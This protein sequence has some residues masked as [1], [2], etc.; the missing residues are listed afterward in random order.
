VRDDIIRESEPRIRRIDHA[1]LAGWD[2]SLAGFPQ[3]SF[4]HGS[5]WARVLRDSYGYTPI[6]LLADGPPHRRAFLPLLEVNSWMTGRRGI[7]LPFTDECAPLCPDGETFRRLIG[8][9]IELGRRRRWRYLE[10]RG[11]SPW[12][13]DAEASTGYYGH[14]LDLTGGEPALYR[15]LE[16]S[17]RRA[18]RKAEASELKVDFFRDLESLRKFYRLLG[19][20]RKKHGL[21]PQ[22]FGFFGNIHR[23]IL[24][25]NQGL[26]VLAHLGKTPVAGA[27]FFQFG[28]TALF[29][30]GASDETYQ[31]LRANNLLM[32]RAIQRFAQQGFE[33]LDFGRTS[34]D[35]EGLRRFKL[36]WGPSE[37]TI[38]YFKYD[39]RAG[40]FIASKDRASGLHTRMFRILP[41]SLA[42]KIGSV[43]YKHLA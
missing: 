1:D 38:N 19:K 42:E 43:L 4:F 35:N 28:R 17:V 10:I 30:Y 37:R 13:P 7:S 33:S 15:G 11:G 9:A 26:I 22:P 20:T 39:L 25:Q 23:H 29:K 8:E 6:G 27:I 5:A 14:R 41:N 12:W 32:W 24:A 3:A 16:S 34:L 18:V 36:S 2:E 31:D 40:R 21:P